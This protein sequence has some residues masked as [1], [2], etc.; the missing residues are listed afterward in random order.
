MP[1]MDSLCNLSRLPRKVRDVNFLLHTWDD[2]SLA[3]LQQ[4]DGAGETKQQG[5]Q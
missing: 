3:R 1:S 4:I 2:V 5:M